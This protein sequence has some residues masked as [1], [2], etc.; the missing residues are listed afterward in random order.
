[1]SAAAGNAIPAAVDGEDAVDPASLAHLAHLADLADD[2]ETLAQLHD[3]ELNVETIA[4]LREIG[5]PDNLA[6]LPQSDATRKAWAAMRAALAEIPDPPQLADLD[7]LAVDFAA[8]Y[9]TGAYGAAPSE[10]FWLDSDHIVCQQPMFEMRDI[11]RA[12]GLKAS[13][14]RLRPDDHLVLQLQYIAHMLRRRITSADFSQ[15][16][17]Q[18][19]DAH[20]MR[21]LP[22]F[23]AGVDA[24][25][26]VPFY[27]ALGYVTLSWCQSLRDTLGPPPSVKRKKPG[28]SR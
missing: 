4:A 21:W 14:W 13:N 23:V 3:V 26:V 15:Q 18:T 6:L 5:F 20:L 28:D 24:R 16:L 7:V 27:A 22:D 10:S 19:M 11:Y 1:M 8:I 17:A 25:A 2:L 12:A 9:L